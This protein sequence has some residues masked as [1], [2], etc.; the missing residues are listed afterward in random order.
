MGSQPGLRRGFA[1]G[2]GAPRGCPGPRRGSHLRWRFLFRLGARQPV[3]RV[4]VPRGAHQALLP[5]EGVRTE[6]HWHRSSKR[7]RAAALRPALALALQGAE[8]ARGPVADPS[9]SVSSSAE[10]TRQPGEGPAGSVRGQ[11]TPPPAPSR[12]PLPELAVRTDQRRE[13]DV[14]GTEQAELPPPRTAGEGRECWDRADGSW[15]GGWWDG[16]TAFRGHR[17]PDCPARDARP[18]E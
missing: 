7:D 5:G 9:A 2:G 15:K 17:R 3:L 13:R 11:G 14:E 8:A 10:W 16:K 4:V 1:P 6:G 12:S 18:R